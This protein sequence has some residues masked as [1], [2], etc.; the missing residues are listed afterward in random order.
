M[1]TYRLI[2]GV[3]IWLAIVAGVWWWRAGGATS[4][5]PDTAVSDLQQFVVGGRRRIP[6][7]NAAYVQRGDPIYV[8]QG[9]DMRQV[10]EI[11]WG[12]EY[13]TDATG[14]AVF[15]SHAPPLSTDARL[16]SYH[17][18]ES[19]D[20]VLATL[21]PPD[22]RRA[23][24]LE[25]ATAFESHHQQ[26]IAELRP[27]VEDALAEAFVVVEQD[28]KTSLA[29]HRPELRALGEKY[30]AEI[31]EKEIVPL[32]KTEI[33]P[34]VREHGE[35]LAT[36]VGKEVW[37]KVS[38]WRFGWRL[39]YDKTRLPERNLTE[40][41]W[42]R[43]LE[44]DASPILESH[45]PDFI[46]L[47]KKILSD[48]SKN[49]KVKAT[50]RASI[51]K[52]ANDPELQ[53]IIWRIVREVIVENPRLKAVFQKHWKSDRARKAFRLTAERL[54]P[55]VVRIGGIIFGTREDGVSPEFTKILRNQILAKD[56]RW[57]V[58]E[59]TGD[60]NQPPAALEVVAGAENGPSPFVLN[61]R[62]ASAD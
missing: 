22:K 55:S 13:A 5:E 41:E 61:T 10:G 52:V 59:T 33:W 56:R 25:M 15:Y 8:L 29:A 21:L 35:P 32:V 42:K 60:S 51:A 31:I 6:L 3:A 30:Q 46:E 23:V 1:K 58:L 54:E 44:E 7:T 34:V 14:E 26:I 40:Q 17:T 39:A 28:L 18:P 36:E 48:V 37:A 45:I 4:D 11:A 62:V 19:M 12:A 53:R 20:W 16:V 9:G 50:I 24:A 49:E 43:F 57:C 27:I 47:Q 2:G 38:L